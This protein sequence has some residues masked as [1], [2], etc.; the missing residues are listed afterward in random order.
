MRIRRW[1]WIWTPMLRSCLMPGGELS[2][3]TIF[4]RMHRND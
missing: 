2:W 1:P 3:S 4:Y